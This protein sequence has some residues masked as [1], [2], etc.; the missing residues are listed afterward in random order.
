MSHV[1]VALAVST[2]CLFN[3]QNT[4]FLPLLTQAAV[5]NICLSSMWVLQTFVLHPLIPYDDFGNPNSML[6]EVGN[7][8]VPWSIQLLSP[9]ANGKCYQRDTCSTNKYFH[10]AQWKGMCPI[11]K[12]FHAVES[13]FMGILCVK[14]YW[15]NLW[16]NL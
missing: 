12:Y 16:F 9:S 14:M 2:S 7:N 3:M 5:T 10:A 8:S 15:C 13:T 6:H 4:Y 11:N 1:P